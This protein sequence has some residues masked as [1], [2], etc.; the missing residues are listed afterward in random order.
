MSG[1]SRHCVL[2]LGIARSGTS[3]VSAMLAA[4]GVDFGNDPKPPDWRNPRGNFEHATL[5]GLNQAALLAVGSRWSDSRPLPGGWRENRAV[6][7]VEWAIGARIDRDFAASPLFG[8]KDPRLVALLPLY[9][10]LLAARGIG[11]SLVTLHRDE[12][13]VR[14]SI[15]KSGYFHGKFYRLR[16]GRL[17]RHY[18][19]G[20]AAAEASHPHLRVAHARLIADPLAVAAELARTLPFGA[21]GVEADPVAGVAA[22]DPSLHRHRR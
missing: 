13:E 22:I 15:A 19:A 20:I 2:V 4:M 5:S 11:L 9:A 16:A 18:M 21:A 7:S 10:D 8:I 14:A 6:R 17:Y 1:A 12:A 3:A